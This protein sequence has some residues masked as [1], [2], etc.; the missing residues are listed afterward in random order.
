LILPMASLQAV[1]VAW[2]GSPCRCSSGV[3]RAMWERSLS[4]SRRKSSASTG[5]PLRAA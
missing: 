5:K 4:A 3:I 1:M 2:S